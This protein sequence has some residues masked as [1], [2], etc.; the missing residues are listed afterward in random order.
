M[1]EG[2]LKIVLCRA[3]DEAS[4]NV[5]AAFSTAQSVYWEEDTDVSCES[6][7]HRTLLL[8]G[9]VPLFLVV[10][11]VPLWFLIVLFLQRDKLQDP[12]MLGTYGF[13]YHFY[14]PKRRYWEVAIMARKALLFVIIGLSNRLGPDL[15]ML[16]A[17][18]VLH[19]SLAAHMWANPFVTDGPNLNRME[20]VSIS[21]SILVFFSGLVFRDP[22]A[23]EAWKIGASAAV[24]I[25]LLVTLSYLLMQLLFEAVKGLEVHLAKRQIAVK[26]DATVLAKM[27]A[28]IRDCL[29]RFRKETGCIVSK[30]CTGGQNPKAPVQHGAQHGRPTQSAKTCSL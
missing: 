1:T 29:G 21:C 7:Q 18:G 2:V 13:L 5:Y 14:T 6:E 10:F 23:S 25:S 28:L 9:A 16:L 11:G 12:Q 30:C 8:G 20:G 4:D 19:I 27:V 3:A 22:D 15:Q 26:D 17:L 24:I